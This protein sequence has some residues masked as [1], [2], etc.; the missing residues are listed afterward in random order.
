M[1]TLSEYQ[2][3]T[4]RVVGT[5]MIWQTERWRRA[6]PFHRHRARLWQ[7]DPPPLPHHLSLRGVFAAQRW[8]P[9]PH[10]HRRAKWQRDCLSLRRRPA[11]RAV[12]CLVGKSRIGKLGQLNPGSRHFRTPLY[13][14]GSYPMKSESAW[15]KARTYRCL[16]CGLGVIWL[17]SD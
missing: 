4:R 11:W 17:L 16:F 8:A 12:L 6:C 13:L 9:H 3:L 7:R 10:K 1:Q 5:S 14:N 2:Q 15:S